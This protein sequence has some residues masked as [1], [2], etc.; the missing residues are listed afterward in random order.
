MVSNT[1]DCLFTFDKFIIYYKVWKVENFEIILVVNNLSNARNCMCKVSKGAKI[2]IR[3]NKVPHLT[4][5]R[6]HF[7]GILYW[8][9]SFA[10]VPS[11]EP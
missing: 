10:T 11:I 3:Y 7:G 4:L 2:G 1:Q 9:T 6:Y 8:P 5:V